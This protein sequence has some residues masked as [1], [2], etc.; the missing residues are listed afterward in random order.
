MFTYENILLKDSF[1]IKEN[2][3]NY[4]D[5]LLVDD[6]I[7]FSSTSLL[8]FSTQIDMLTTGKWDKNTNL[9]VLLHTPS[10]YLK[11][12]INDRPITVPANKLDRI[13]NTYRKQ[14]DNYHGLGIELVKQLPQA[15][16]KPIL[17]VQSST[18]ND[19]IVIVT[20][21]LDKQKKVVIISYYSMVKE[22]LKYVILAI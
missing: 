7:T 4:N 17:I 16:E 9:I 12:G 18:R 5:S 6:T 13:I 15:I 20:K 21:L 10:L 3:F 1:N 8:S 22:I 2:D 14:K 11:M 19:S